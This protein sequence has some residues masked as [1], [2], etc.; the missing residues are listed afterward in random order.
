MALARTQSILVAGMEISVDKN[1]HDDGNCS[2]KDGS[3]F[4]TTH[5]VRDTGFLTDEGKIALFT[6]MDLF[7]LAAEEAFSDISVT[8]DEGNAIAKT[9]SE[10]SMRAINHIAL[11]ADALQG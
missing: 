11:F 3:L 8:E 9:I 4:C 5:M 7:L 1:I 2:T 10:L 6:Q